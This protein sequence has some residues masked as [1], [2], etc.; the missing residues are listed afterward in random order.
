[1][2]RTLGKIK[3]IEEI[4][5][6]KLS[7]IS[8]L[9]GSGGRLGLSQMINGF[10]GYGEKDGYLV[11]TDKHTWHLLID[12]GQSCC[13]SWGYLW[14]DDDLSRY[15]EKELLKVKVTD[16]ALNTKMIEK[17][18]EIY[19]GAIKFVDFIFKDDVLQFAVYNNHNGYYGHD[20]L[21]ARDKKI[22][23]SDVL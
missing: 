9:D 6:L 16:V 13:E 19:E 18:K 23:L 2:N 3:K 17:E 7:N 5:G 8:N 4:N 15:I 14:S 11:E 22:I 1:M 10:C 20:I 12:N 21:I